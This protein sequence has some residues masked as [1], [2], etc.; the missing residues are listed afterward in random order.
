VAWQ[1]AQNRFNSPQLAKEMNTSFSKMM[2]SASS[3][4]LLVRAAVDAPRRHH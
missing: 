1:W 2:I 3:F 4:N